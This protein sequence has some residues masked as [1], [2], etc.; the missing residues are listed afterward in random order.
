MALLFRWVVIC[1]AVLVQARSVTAKDGDTVAGRT[2][3]ELVTALDDDDR[4]TRCAAVR[5]LGAFEQSGA[6]ALAGALSHHDPAVR[7]LAA[8]HLGRIGGEE[9]SKAT[10]RLIGLAEK[11]DSEAVRMAVSFALCRGGKVESHLP[12]LIAGL[13][14][15]ERAMACSAAELI[16][17]LGPAASEARERL[18][19]VRDANAPGSDGDYHIGGAAAAA[20]RKIDAESVD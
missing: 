6:K 14:A 2:V 11:D 12:R 17:M 10:D 9:L 13:Q 8:V 18:Q 19:T 7:Y 5:S 16:G 4:T 20:L 15:S 3:A 1:L